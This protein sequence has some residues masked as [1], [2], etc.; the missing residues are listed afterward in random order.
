MKRIYS[1]NTP[2]EEGVLQL[3]KSML[4][5]I[6][7]T[8]IV[9]NESLSIGKG[10]IPATECIPELW[11][12]EDKDY[13]KAR[14]TVDEWMRSNSESHASWLCPQCNEMMEGQFTSCWKCGNERKEE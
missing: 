6:P 13:S 4:E 8:C 14:T 11:I 5:E 2:A 7:I 1:A 12:L 10:D 3:L 9:R